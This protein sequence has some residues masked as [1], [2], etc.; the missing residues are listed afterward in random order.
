MVLIIVPVHDTVPQHEE[1]PVLNE[2][3]RRRNVCGSGGKAPRV[4]NLN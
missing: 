2:T 3:S 4:L 1:V